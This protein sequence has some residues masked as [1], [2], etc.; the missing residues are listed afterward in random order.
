[1]Q[2]ASEAATAAHALTPLRLRRAPRSGCQELPVGHA[3][4]PSESAVP[5]LLEALDTPS[6]P[7][8]PEVRSFKLQSLSCTRAAS[9]QAPSSGSDCD[10][11]LPL[12]LD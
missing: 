7:V 8:Q 3:K 2:P 9:P 12:D 5:V 4:V 11:R 10:L 6:E 1:M